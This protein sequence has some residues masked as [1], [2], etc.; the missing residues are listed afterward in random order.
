MGAL[1]KETL[2]QVP[3]CG[4]VL[5]F[6]SRRADRIKLLVWDGSGLVLVWKRLEQGAFKWPPITNGV[7]RLSPAQLAA[8]VEGLVCTGARTADCAA[9]G[10]ATSAAANYQGGRKNAPCEREYGRIGTAMTTAEALPG[11]MTSLRAA[12]L[13]L[14]AE[15]YELLRRVERMRQ[16]IRQFQRAQSAGIRSGSTLTSGSSR[17][18][19]AKLRA[20]TS[21]R[22]RN[23][24]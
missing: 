7:M 13:A 14:T 5:V 16:I 22:R 17:S 10:D 12:A 24:K 6:R 20:R 2:A 15:R 9:A 18:K 23:S 8:L 19:N 1:A 4:A 21:R 11:D 3:F